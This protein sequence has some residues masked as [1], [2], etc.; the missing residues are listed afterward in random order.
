MS[1]E[2]VRRLEQDGIVA[3]PGLVAG[4][5]LAA[6]QGAFAARLRRMR[7][8]HF[9]GYEKTETGR[10]MVQDVL[11]LDRGFVDLA[12][13]S[14]VT[15]TLRG[16]L[17]E[18]FELVEAKGW[19]S[20]PT[21][22]DYHGWHGDAWYDQEAVDFI[23]REVKLGLYLTDVRSGAFAYVKGSHGRQAPRL[24]PARETRD[25]PAEAIVTMTGPAGTAFLFDTSGVHRQSMPILEPREA[26]FLNYHDP[27]IPLQRE[28]LDYYRYHPLLLNAA[29]LGGLSDEDRRILGFG[30]TTNFIPAFERGP[31]HERFQA[32][33]RAAFGAKLRLDALRGRVLGRLGRALRV[34]ARSVA[35]HR[36]PGGPPEGGP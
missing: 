29:F 24:Y 7:W 27:S 30:N 34:G 18:R 16:Y 6:M 10:L 14:V 4:D 13:H 28:D 22:K 5:R 15:A 36:A 8:N 12:L 2:L 33:A 3:V 1:D 31:E 9:D 17:G 20:L 32:A 23:P 25:L 35:P 19:R 21:R 26:I 11:T